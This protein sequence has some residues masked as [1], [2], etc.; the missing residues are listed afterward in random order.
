MPGIAGGDVVSGRVIFNITCDSLNNMCLAFLLCA[1]ILLLCAVEVVSEAE[2]CTCCTFNKCRATFSFMYSRY[3]I[4]A[5]DQNQNCLLVT[6]QNNNHS[7]GPG[8]GRLVPSSH[9]RSKLSN[10]ILGALSRGDKRFQ[11]TLLNIS[12]GNWDLI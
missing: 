11:S 3:Y 2:A 4:I 7:P 6:R 5:V 12:I 10:S 8:P 9:Q 1:V